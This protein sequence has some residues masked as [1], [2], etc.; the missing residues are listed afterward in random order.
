M[1]HS[2]RTQN[3]S[4]TRTKHKQ[5]YVTKKVF[6]EY[7]INRGYMAHVQTYLQYAYSL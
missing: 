2:F 6:V 1:H 3:Y 4:K 5:I 7:K